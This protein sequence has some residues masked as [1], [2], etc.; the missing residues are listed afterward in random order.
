M[1]TKRS[2]RWNGELDS[3][4]PEFLKEVLGKMEAYG[5]RVQFE[6]PNKSARPNYQVISTSNRKMGFDSKHLLLR[7]NEDGNVGEQLT[8][9]FSLEAIRTAM[10][11]GGKKPAGSRASTVV[12]R[13]GAS[14][15]ASRSA[16]AA[17]AAAVDEV[18]RDKYAYFKANRE[19]LPE[20]ITRY[21]QQISDLM[22]NGMSA[23]NAF[24]AIIKQN[25]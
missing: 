19:Y 22:R 24:E 9:E 13:S 20:G 4:A 6:Q 2:K 3:L 11:G 12:R 18:E 16:P 14:G 7:L 21:S 1:S 15:G 25:F 8:S 17:A 10:N 5:D 23:E